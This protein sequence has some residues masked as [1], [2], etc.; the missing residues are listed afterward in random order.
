MTQGAIHA[1]ERKSILRCR[2]CVWAHPVWWTTKSGK[3]VSGWARFADHLAD[4]HPE[5][6][7]EDQVYMIATGEPLR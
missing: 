4:I 7:M 3:R 5:K 6:V 2:F 1:E